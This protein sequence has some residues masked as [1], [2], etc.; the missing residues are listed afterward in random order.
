[1]LN[2]DSMVEELTWPIYYFAGVIGK[3]NPYKEVWSNLLSIFAYMWRLAS[4]AW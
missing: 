2:A 1:M 3:S 4:L